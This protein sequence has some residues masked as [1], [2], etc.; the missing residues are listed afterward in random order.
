MNNLSGVLNSD[1][2]GRR[3]KLL[4][5]LPFDYKDFQ[6][7]ISNVGESIQQFVNEKYVNDKRVRELCKVPFYAVHYLE[8][9]IQHR[10][11]LGSFKIDRH[12]L[13]LRIFLQGV[14]HKFIPKEGFL[15][16][17]FILS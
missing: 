9:L 11:T 4:A 5:L 3:H 10:A 15:K 17:C 1:E 2:V 8:L 13:M 6:L 7:L 16:V 14:N 12:G